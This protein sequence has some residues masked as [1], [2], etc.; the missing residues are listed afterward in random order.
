MDSL[1]VR[2]LPNN[3]SMRYRADHQAVPS[4]EELVWLLRTVADP[5]LILYVDGVKLLGKEVA[6]RS[7]LNPRSTK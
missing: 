5:D 4:I 3:S 1:P 2:P 6:L 7:L